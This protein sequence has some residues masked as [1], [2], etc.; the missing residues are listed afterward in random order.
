MTEP[1]EAEVLRVPG[2]AWQT[3]APPARHAVPVRYVLDLEV[4][5]DVTIGLPGHYFLD[6]QVVARAERGRVVP[7]GG[8][9]E[10]EA[11]GVAAPFA[12]W[13]S[14][15]FPREGLAMQLWPLDWCW[16][17]RDALAPGERHAHAPRPDEHPHGEHESWLAHVRPGLREPPTRHPRPAR[18][19]ASLT[20]R[21]VRLQHEPEAWS[22]WVAVSEPVDHDGDVVVHLLSP[23]HYWLAQVSAE[24]PGSVRAV[25]L[26]RLYTYD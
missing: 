16:T 14:R 6:G 7:V 13:V 9:Q 2:I 24:P 26:Y 8:T 22:W 3:E 12:Y 1:W 21:T 10:V 19:A 20:G 23:S 11:L 18:D 17:Y 25:P 15:G 4:G 5:D